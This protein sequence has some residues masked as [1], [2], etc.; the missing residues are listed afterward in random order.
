LG[1]FWRVLEWKMLVLFVGIW[2][3]PYI[4][5]PFDI[6]CVHLVYFSRF[7]MLGPGNPADCTIK[8]LLHS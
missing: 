7:G 8:C 1:I 3:I 5:W 4:L 6:V 2:T